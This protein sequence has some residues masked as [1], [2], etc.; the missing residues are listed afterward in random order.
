VLND[1]ALG[2]VK[3]AQR[4][5]HVEQIGCDLPS[6]DFAA[7][8]RALGSEAYTIRNVHDLQQ[9]DMPMLCARRGP[10]LLDVIISTDEIPPI[11]ARLSAL[12]PESADMIGEVLRASLP[13]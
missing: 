7:L 12:K 8:A 10:T 5:R 6:V 3:H 2:M 11:Q 9:L 1:H 4:L 13:G